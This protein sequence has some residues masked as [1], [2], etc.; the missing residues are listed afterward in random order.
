MRTIP[1]IRPLT[2]RFWNA[3]HLVLGA[4]IASLWLFAFA[5]HAGLWL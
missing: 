2:N 1:V 3:S 4:I 5:I